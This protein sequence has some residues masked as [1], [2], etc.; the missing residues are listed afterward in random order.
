ME[1]DSDQEHEQDQD[2]SDANMSTSTSTSPTHTSLLQSAIIYGQQLGMEYPDSET[3]RG[4]KKGLGDAFSLVAYDDPASSPFGYLLDESRRVDVAEEVGGAILS[5]LLTSL[6]LCS[7][8]IFQTTC[9]EID[10]N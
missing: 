5:T 6:L 2:G 3:T 1:L 7:F 4:F 8:P 9:E 10:G